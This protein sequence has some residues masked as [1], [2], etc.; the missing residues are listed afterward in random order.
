MNLPP[1]ELLEATHQFPGPYTVKAIGNRNDLFAAQIVAAARTALGLDVDPPFSCRESA[2]GK[3]VAVTLQ[4]S[5]QSA[6]QV[7]AVYERVLR[8][9]DLLLLL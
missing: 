1:I 9:P 6:R 2:G 4:L 7:H 5:V 8:V 3:H